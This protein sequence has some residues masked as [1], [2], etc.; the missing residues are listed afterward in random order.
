MIDAERLLEDLNRRA[1]DP[2]WGALMEASIDDEP[3]T[4]EDLE[5]IREAEEAIARGD[6]TDF[7]DVR[8]RVLGDP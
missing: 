3:L 8:R 5:A 6:I 2:L 4:E 1:Q 7:E